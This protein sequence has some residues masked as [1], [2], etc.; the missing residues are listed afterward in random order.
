MKKIIS[1]FIILTVFLFGTPLTFAEGD[2]L[3]IP[4]LFFSSRLFE[5]SVYTGGVNGTINSLGGSVTAVYQ[6]IYL[7][8]SGET[9]IVASEES[10][11]NLLSTNKV[12]FDRSD[13]TATL[14]YAIDNSISVF[15]GYKYG[16]STI[17]AL[18]PSPYEGAKISLE[19]KGLFLGAGGR[20]GVKDWGFLSFSAAYAK[21]VTFYK[22]LALGTAEGDA[23]GTS[24]VIQWKS[25]LTENLYYDVSLIR[26]DYYYE[27][28]DK[29]DWD[30]SEQIF[31]S[32]IGMSYRF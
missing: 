20:W 19:G 3:I 28:F 30:I 23:S 27:N 1:R 15:G 5:Y 31:S 4:N 11:T 18:S 7:D 12:A 16:K 24:L 25:A 14:G 29:F 10:T 6:P 9:N 8:L 22:D 17:T 21:M 26:H 32:R 13:F 2:I